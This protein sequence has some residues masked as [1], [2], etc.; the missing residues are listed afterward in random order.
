VSTKPG[1]RYLRGPAE[2]AQKGTRKE[3]MRHVAKYEHGLCRFCVQ[4]SDCGRAEEGI[5]SCPEFEE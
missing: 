5:Y 2:K 3:G 1:A 4:A